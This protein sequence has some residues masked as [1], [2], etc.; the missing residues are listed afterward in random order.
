MICIR[1]WFALP[2]LKEQMVI[3]SK[4]TKTIHFSYLARE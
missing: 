1:M 2:D 4:T 3:K